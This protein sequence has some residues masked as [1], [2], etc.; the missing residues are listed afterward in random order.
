MTTPV[1]ETRRFHL[2]DILTVTTDK[3]LA[4][5]GVDGVYDL[6]GFMTGDSVAT[7]QWPRLSDECAP[8]LLEQHPELAQIVVPDWPERVAPGTVWAWLAEQTARYGETLPVTPLAA[9][10]HTSIDPITE[11]IAMREASR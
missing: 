10:D 5:K 11:L 8:R 9:V 3:F 7:H 6:L 1:P 4:V 2:G